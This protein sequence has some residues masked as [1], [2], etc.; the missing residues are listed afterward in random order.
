MLPS[1]AINSP[2]LRFWDTVCIRPDNEKPHVLI[3]P[4][5]SDSI[6]LNT[7]NAVKHAGCTDIPM[8]VT[9]GIPV[10]VELAGGPPNTVANFPLPDAWLSPTYSMFKQRG[11]KKFA[12]LGRELHPVSMG[13]RSLS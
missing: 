10:Y 8:L 11:A 12:L 1:Q 5:P 6:M 9:D 13:L 2:Y 7:I 3:S 4:V